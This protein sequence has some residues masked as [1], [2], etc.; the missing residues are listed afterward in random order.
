MIDCAICASDRKPIINGLLAAGRGPYAIEN[1]MKR[2]GSPTRAPTVQRHLRR[3]LNGDPT[4]TEVLVRSLTGKPVSSNADFATA[5]RNEAARL[6]EEGQLKVRTVDGLAAQG[7]LD[8]RAEKQADRMLL[9]EM[10]RLLSG[11]GKLGTVRPP[12]GLMVRAMVLDAPTDSADGET[13]E[14]EPD[15]DLQLPAMRPVFSGR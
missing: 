7:L 15:S 5:V 12:E 13:A 3:C 10:A 1:E 6:L 9:V 14:Q 8:R 4:N 2:L 11:A